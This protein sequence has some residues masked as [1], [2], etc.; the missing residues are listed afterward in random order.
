LLKEE[1]VDFKIKKD[2]R[3]G[4]AQLICRQNITVI[5]EQADNLLL[6]SAFKMLEMLNQDISSVN[7]DRI[8]QF[9]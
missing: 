1:N 8:V 9:C 3:F 7:M 4:N 6:S 5:D 2:N